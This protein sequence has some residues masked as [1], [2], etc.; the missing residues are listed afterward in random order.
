MRRRRRHKKRRV[1]V[2]RLWTQDEV[3]RAVPYLRS[4]VGSLREHWLRVQSVER[5]RARLTARPG[6]RQRDRILAEQLNDEHRSR[7]EDQFHDALAEL[8]KIDVFLL[9]PVHGLALIPFRR[10][11]D[12]AWFVYD[13]FDKDGLVGWR[14]HE[15]PLEQCRP[16]KNLLGPVATDSI[17]N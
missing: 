1:R 4:V 3:T 8:S 2:L 10:E 6:A 13:H 5:D 16:L 11:D 7:A 14:L 15:D 9:D 12:L 17:P